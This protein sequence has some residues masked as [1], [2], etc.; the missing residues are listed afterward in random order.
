MASYQIPA[1]E[2]FDFKR[3][4]EWPRWIRRFERFHQASD[5]TT[6]SQESQVSTLIY[7]MGDKADDILN[8]TGDDA[9]TYTTVKGKCESHFVKRRNTT[10]FERAKFNQRK[11]EE[12]EQ[13]DDFITDL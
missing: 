10:I 3:P 6:K 5:L 8:L 4:E 13:V 9:K 7:A 2:R 11:Q 12:G 1:L